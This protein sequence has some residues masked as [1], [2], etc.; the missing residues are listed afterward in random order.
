M[1]PHTHAPNLMCFARE[2][3]SGEMRGKSTQ[4][5]LT[6]LKRDIFVLNQSHCHKSQGLGSYVIMPP[7]GLVMWSCLQSLKKS[8]KINNLS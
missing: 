7:Q 6:S 5:V 4:E 8:W 2:L 3:M 1:L